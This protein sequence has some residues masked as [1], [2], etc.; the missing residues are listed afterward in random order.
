[1]VIQPG[2]LTARQHYLG[3]ERE[4]GSYQNAE[5]QRQTD[6][7][8]LV[9]SRGLQPGQ[10]DPME[11]EWRNDTPNSLIFCFCGPPRCSDAM[12]TRG[13]DHAD[14]TLVTEQLENAGRGSGR[15]KGAVQHRTAHSLP[16]LQWAQW[17]RHRFRAAWKAR[18]CRYRTAVLEGCWLHQ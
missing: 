3:L 7:K 1:M 4:E 9:L 16:S 8:V 18:P 13:Q 17:S 11:Y 14:Q 5:R 15:A 2:L 10:H 6:R 12:R